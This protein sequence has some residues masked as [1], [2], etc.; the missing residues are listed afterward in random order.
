MSHTMTV[1]DNMI[2]WLYIAVFFFWG[3]KTQRRYL[4]ENETKPG[5]VRALNI[6][7]YYVIHNQFILDRHEE[8]AC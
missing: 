5:F 6:H 1:I 2:L 8:N 7:I 4:N 3:R